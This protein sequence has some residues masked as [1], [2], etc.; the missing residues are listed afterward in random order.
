MTHTDLAVRGRVP[1]FDHRDISTMRRIAP[2]MPNPL[3][4][5]VKAKAD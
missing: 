4:G 5:L 2:P 3:A 1:A